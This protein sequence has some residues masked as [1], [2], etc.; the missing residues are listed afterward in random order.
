MIKIT[1]LIL[2]SILLMPL[3]CSAR[4]VEA[5]NAK[6]VIEVMQY[7]FSN[8]VEVANDSHPF[9]AA[10][11]FN[12]DGLKDIAVLF[13]PQKDIRPS[14]QIQLSCPWA[15]DS[16][17]HSNRYHKSLAIINGHPDGWMSP[18]TKVFVLIDKSGVLETPSFQM[19]VKKRSESDYAQHLKLLP[20][21]K[22]GDFI[23]LPTEA[24][25]DTYILWDRSNYKLH[26]PEEIP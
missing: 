19:I 3:N 22:F 17:M 2:L 11:D 13:Y 25:I 23:I 14:K 7:Y 20:S 4:D 8:A 16:G 24:G 21:Y 12:D 9:Y 26:I 10:G 15:F 1:S 5:I 6:T 18:N